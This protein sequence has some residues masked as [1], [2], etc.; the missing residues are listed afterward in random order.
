VPNQTKEY[1]VDKQFGTKITHIFNPNTYP[2]I[3]RR[4]KART[5]TTEWFINMQTP[6]IDGIFNL[7]SNISR[8]QDGSWR[9]GGKPRAGKFYDEVRTNVNTPSDAENW[10]DVEITGYAKINSIVVSDI[11]TSD[12]DLTWYARG[13]RHNAHIRCEVGLI[14]FN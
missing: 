10:K 7:Q 4:S 14:R 8:Q 6:T 13:S 3:N 11:D 12:D 1:R 5:D 2:V 9:I